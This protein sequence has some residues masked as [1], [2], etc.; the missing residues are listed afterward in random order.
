ML[1]WLEVRLDIGYD[2]RL[3][4]EYRTEPLNSGGDA[5]KQECR[6]VRIVCSGTQQPTHLSEE[7]Q[8]ATS[9]CPQTQSFER[10]NCRDWSYNW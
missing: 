3:M 8:R 5:L 1:E 7:I 6:L 4:Y 2:K 9:C 10:D